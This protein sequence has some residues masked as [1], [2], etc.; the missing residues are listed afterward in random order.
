MVEAGNGAVKTVSWAFMAF[1]KSR[2]LW[3]PAWV[4]DETGPVTNP[5]WGQ[6]GSGSPASASGAFKQVR[7]PE[8]DTLSSAVLLSLTSGS[9]LGGGDPCRVAYL[10]FTL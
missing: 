5:S 7:L 6:M 3:S 9:Q 2:L 4:Q 1:M 8:E 10:I